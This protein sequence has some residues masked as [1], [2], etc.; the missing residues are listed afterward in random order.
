[1]KKKRVL[2]VVLL[3]AL[4]ASVATI[5]YLTKNTEDPSNGNESIFVVSYTRDDIESVSIENE[6]DS[7][8]FSRADNE[9]GFYCEKIDDLPQLLSNYITVIDSV[10]SIEAN[11]EY[12]DSDLSRYGLDK[13]QS[14]AE[15]T[16]KTGETY[17]VMVGSRA[18]SENYVYFAVS[19][20]P[21]TV[22][23]ARL[24]K[25][26]PLL[27]NAY[28]LV[29]KLLAPKTESPRPGNDETDTAHSLEFT[30]RDGEAFHLDQLSSSYRDGAGNSYRYHQTMPY[31]TYVQAAKVQD[32]FS[33]VMQFCASSVYKNHPTEEDIAECGLDDPLTMLKLGYND[34]SVTIYL[35]LAP[36]GD[37][38]AM[39]EGVDV[40]WNVADYLVTWLDVQDDTFRCSYVMAPPMDTA[41]GVTVTFFDTENS[42]DHVYHGDTY[43]IV[44]NEDGTGTINNKPVNK[45]DMTRLYTL[46]C[47]VNSENET[48]T[49]GGDIVVRIQ[50][51]L[52]GSVRILDLRRAESRT[53]IIYTDDIFSTGLSIRESFA[54][55]LHEACRAVE[56]GG[57]FSTNW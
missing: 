12:P 51:A 32:V 14:V 40:I 43:S 55:T 45:G 30:N 16:L 41:N 19:T 4:I 42:E 50:F 38:Y 23:T 47:S 22:Y 15:V 39:K 27:T 35:S 48:S 29:N 56:N 33:R 24:S 21:N 37:Y 28:S 57:A 6:L 7:F 52:K 34:D 49:E 9:I 31:E 17:K 8:S 54:D 36:N 5:I 46:L 20:E 53:L 25:F 26:T 1:M 11:S 44:I 13:P 10:C 3:V 18:P 2:F